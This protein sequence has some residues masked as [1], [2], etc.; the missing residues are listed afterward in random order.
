MN[1]LSYITRKCTLIMVFMLECFSFTEFSV[2]SEWSHVANTVSL[3]E[4]NGRVKSFTRN[5]FFKNNNFKLKEITN[6]KKETKLVP[7][8]L[9][10][11]CISLTI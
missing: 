11:C 9:V 8:V 3:I 10:A 6:H 5:N 4:T 1:E 2:I 7:L